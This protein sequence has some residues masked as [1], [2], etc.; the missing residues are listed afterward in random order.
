[1]GKGSK[2]GSEA[3]DKGKSGKGK[4]Q[5]PAYPNQAKRKT[6]EKTLGKRTSTK[7]RDDDDEFVIISKHISWILRHGAKRVNLNLDADGWVNLKDLIEL[8]VMDNIAEEKIMQVIE[9]SNK[10]KRRYEVEDTTDGGKRIRALT[11]VERK[12]GLRR[13]APDFSPFMPY[14]A[15]NGIAPMPY[16]WPMPGFGY[17]PMMPGFSP[18]S[19]SMASGA[20]VGRFQGRIKS[21]NAEKGFGFIESDA[22]Y[23]HYN[24]DVFVHKAVIGSLKIGDMVTFGVQTNE[25]GMPQ[26]RDLAIMPSNSA[27][28]PSANFGRG[29]KGKGGQG[30]AGR[31][32]GKETKSTEKV[33]NVI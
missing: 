12:A 29:G 23:A 25:Q 17:M 33:E 1:M 3:P 11:K 22:A 24:R 9:E 27:G 30:K 21:Y 2:K 7:D 26:A 10:E 28:P 6:L 20:G 31:G 32:K 5:R 13:D 14:P 15:N 19:F 18:E 8:E 16:P 4:G